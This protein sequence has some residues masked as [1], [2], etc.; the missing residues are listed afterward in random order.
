MT[1]GASFE[2]EAAPV[3]R[4]LAE[5]AQQGRGDPDGKRRFPSER[6]EE[7]LPDLVGKLPCVVRVI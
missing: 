3:Q 5:M 4:E 1:P 2:T 7:G 6:L